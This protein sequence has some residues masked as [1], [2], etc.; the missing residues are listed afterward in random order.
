MLDLNLPHQTGG[1][2]TD[3]STQFIPSAVAETTLDISPNNILFN[4]LMGR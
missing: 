4:V 3:Q 2:H 1:V